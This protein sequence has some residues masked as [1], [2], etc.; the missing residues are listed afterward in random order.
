MIKTHLMA[1]NRHAG[2]MEIAMASRMEMERTANKRVD[3]V[4]NILR[5]AMEFRIGRLINE[6]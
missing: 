3:L 1:A 4:E 6:S 2:G 5:K